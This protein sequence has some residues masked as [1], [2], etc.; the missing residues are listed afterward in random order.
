RRLA[1]GDYDRVAVDE[2]RERYMWTRIREHLATSGL[3][4]ADCLYVCG[5]F[6]AASRVDEFGLGGTDTFEISPR[7]STKWQ[8]GLIPSS[9]SAIEAQFGLASGSVSIAAAVWAKSV[10]RSGVSPFRLEGQQG[11]ATKKPK[12]VKA[13]AAAHTTP[14]DQLSRFL[15]RPPVLD[16][17]DEAEL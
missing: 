3:T 10:T 4:S 2:D 6:H 12:A 16:G 5:A 7:T 9:H 1:P 8:Y 17:L 11:R 14:T 15:A 13:T